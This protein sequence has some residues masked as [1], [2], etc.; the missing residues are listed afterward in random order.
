MN[1]EA[2][3]HWGLSHNNNNNNNNKAHARIRAIYGFVSEQN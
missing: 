3:A 1:E 2:L